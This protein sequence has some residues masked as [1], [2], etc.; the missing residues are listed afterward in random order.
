[1][2][3][4]FD[5]CRNWESAAWSM[6]SP[7]VYLGC[8][9]TRNIW[10]FGDA[11]LFPWQPGSLARLF[12][13]TSTTSL[14]CWKVMNVLYLRKVPWWCHEVIEEDFAW[15]VY[16]GCHGNSLFCLAQWNGFVA[17]TDST[18]VI[19]CRFHHFLQPELVFCHIRQLHARKCWKNVY[20][21]EFQE[22]SL[23]TQITVQFVSNQNNG[24][25]N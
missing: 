15:K 4:L 1:M 12:S 11:F 3:A 25:L 9:A 16:L 24:N 7:K 14:P 13:S 23:H 19:Y 20:E 17:K 8:L 18:S 21:N 22:G 6:K 2:S 5:G 10:G